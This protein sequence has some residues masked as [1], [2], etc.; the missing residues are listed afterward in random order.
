MKSNTVI[1]GEDKRYPAD[2]FNHADVDSDGKIKVLSYGSND[3]VGT[4]AGGRQRVS[5]LTTL[6]DGKLTNNHNSLLFEQAGTGSFTKENGNSMLMEV[7]AGQWAVYSGRNRVPYFSGKSQIIE[8][9]F[10]QFAPQENVVKEFGYFSSNNASPYNSDYDGLFV[11]SSGGSI[12]FVVSNAGT[13]LFDDD[14]TDWTGYDRLAEYQTLSTWDNFTVCMIDFLWLGGA[15]ARLWIKTSN[16]FVLAHQV[17]WAGTSQGTFTKTP[18]HSV[19]FQIR[20]TTGTGSFRYVCS[21]IATEGSVN[22]SG[23]SRSAYTPYLGVVASTAG[24]TYPI[25]GIT[26]N[27]SHVG[28]PVRLVKL[29]IFTL[30][31]N[32]SILWTLQIN[33]ELSAP[34]SYTNDVANSA[35]SYALGNGTITVSTEGTVVESGYV[36]QGSN[37]PVETLEENFIAW[38]GQAMNDTVDKYVICATPLNT[39]TNVRTYASIGYEEF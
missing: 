36:T 1:I 17:D 29:D 8:E 14:I 10:D 11:R 13:E 33:P 5:Q 7:T 39:I 12:S 6:F 28:V 38:I 2:G 32:D 27:A 21:Q 20:S 22:E 37:I 30:S 4:D 9:T 31:V 34:L 3:W 25:L 24:T 23:M 18:S 26:K 19:R 16:G 35:V 15:V